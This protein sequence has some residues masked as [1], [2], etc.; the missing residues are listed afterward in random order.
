MIKKKDQMREEVRTD[1]LG[2]TGDVTF[3][4]M[5]ESA[6]MPGKAKLCAILILP[7]GA[8]IGGHV[9]D[10]DAEIYIITK[11]TAMVDDNGTMCTLSAGDSV[12]TSPGENH[13]ISNAGDIPLELFAIVIE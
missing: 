10:P 11:G 12:Y 2:G 7:V 8:S 9:H 3:V 1:I 5:L 13:S 4:H 6:E